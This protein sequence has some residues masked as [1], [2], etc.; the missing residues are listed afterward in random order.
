MKHYLSNNFLIGN[1]HIL[2]KKVIYLTAKWK[3]GKKRE[4]V[5]KLSVLT[6]VSTRKI[7]E[8]YIQPLIMLGILAEFGDTI[9]F[10]D[11]S[12]QGVSL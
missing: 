2:M 10:V 1:I 4:L 8:D 9:K 3:S 6:C 5:D 7:G 12:K 11:L